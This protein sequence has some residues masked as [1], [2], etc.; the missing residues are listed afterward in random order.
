MISSAKQALSFAE[1]RDAGFVVRIPDEIDVAS[2]RQK[3]DM[4]QSEFAGYY[5][6][7]H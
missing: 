7:S 1:G 5:R 3:L 4:S 2:I 6:T